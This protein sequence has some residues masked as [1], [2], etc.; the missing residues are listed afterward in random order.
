MFV[1]SQFWRQ[2]DLGQGREQVGSR[3]GVPSV[4]RPLLVG[5]PERL[6]VDLVYEVG[7]SRSLLDG[8]IDLGA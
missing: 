2:C 6:E 8:E 5:Q 3:G 4:G 1:D 7:V